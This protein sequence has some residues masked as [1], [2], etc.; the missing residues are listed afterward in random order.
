MPGPG[1]CTCILA[2]LLQPAHL[3]GL[4]VWGS[5]VVLAA[6]RVPLRLGH[7]TR[8]DQTRLELSFLFG[9]PTNHGYF[10]SFALGSVKLIGSRPIPFLRRSKYL[11]ITLHAI[12]YDLPTSIL[13]VCRKPGGSHSDASLHSPSGPVATA[14][15][16]AALSSRDVSDP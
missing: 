14:A 12:L 8:L 2:I 6:R 11:Q 13:H 7:S 1:P 15:A 3:V 9:R 16:A 5:A 10:F 4:L